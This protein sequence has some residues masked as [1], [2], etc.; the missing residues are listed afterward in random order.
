[1]LR[2]DRLII[3]KEVSKIPIPILRKIPSG[4]LSGGGGKNGAVLIMKSKE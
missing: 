2:I 3:R 4:I 1:M